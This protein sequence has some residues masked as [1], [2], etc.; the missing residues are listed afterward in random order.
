MWR[1]IWA[2]TRKDLY[3]TYTDRN[4]LLIMLATPLTIATIIGAA[5]SG[6][7]GTSSD[8]P[9]YNIPLAVVNLD[10]GAS[11]GREAI[12]Q[13]QIFEDVL[14]PPAGATEAD[15]NANG[16][17][18][19]TDAVA[20]ND[21]SEARTM[22]DSGQLAAAVIIP[23]NFSQQ[24]TYSPGQQSLGS[25]AV[26][27]YVNAGAQVEGQIIRSIVESITTRIANGNI[28]VAATI[29]ALVSRA[30]SDLVFGL[31]FIYAMLSGAFQPDFS[32]AYQPDNTPILIAMQSVTG[33]PASFNPLVLFG[34]AQALFFMIFTAMG[35]VNSTLEERRNGTLQRM[36]VSPTPQFAI[37]V[38]KV[39]GAFF[40]SIVQVAILFVAFTLV[41]SLL[42]GQFE[43]IW[44]NNLLLTVAVILASAFAATGLAS[45]V[46]AIAR[47]P[48]QGDI[49]GSLIAIV[50]GIF[51][52][53]F[54]SIPPIPI[55]QTLS[56]LT[57]N[58]W[59]VSAFT[60]LSLGDTGIGL[61]LLVLIV[62][63]AVFLTIGLFLFSRRLKA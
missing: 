59:G 19:L 37:L 52:G 54:F 51:S 3:L 26:E 8:V 11:T 58:Y 46:S 60:K 39:S 21:A 27:V 34:S 48:E 23:A 44:G 2:I 14:V 32:A 47:T 45:V 42:A 17:F 41:G 29:Q 13:G 7:A 9:I 43:M 61:N 28:T 1:K 38:G 6:I 33:E 36:A 30:Q 20:L 53:A 25:T 57:L 55:M 10:T 12:N 4:L 24:L 63:G 49:A 18:L 15:L 5:F 22:V 35:S 40:N 16:V 50:F 62:F 56:K 31:Q